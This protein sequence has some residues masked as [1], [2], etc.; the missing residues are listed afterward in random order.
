VIGFLSAVAFFALFG[1]LL[2]SLWF[3][4]ARSARRSRQ[5]VEVLSAHIAAAAAGPPKPETV[6]ARAG[7]KASLGYGALL[8]LVVLGCVSDF[9]RHGGSGLLVVG[10]LAVAGALVMLRRAVRRPTQFVASRDGFTLASGQR[11]VAWDDVDQ[12]CVTYAQT[13]YT[14]RHHLVLKLRSDPTAAHPAFTTN[15]TN[16]DE[17]E[18]SLDGLSSSW[19]DIAARIA[20]ISGRPMGQTRQGPLGLSSRPLDTQ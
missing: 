20:A 8:C 4:I 18:V 14:E 9:A 16:P 13:A 3:V 17:I 19:Q 1:G 12:I 10:L 6:V 5:N 15:R 11:F 2:W 7:T